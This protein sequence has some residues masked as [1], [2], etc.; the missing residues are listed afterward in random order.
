MRSDNLKKH[1]KICKKNEDVSPVHST[2]NENTIGDILNKVH[3][4]AQDRTANFSTL[5]QSK[6]EALEFKPK[7]D[8]PKP[9]AEIHSDSDSE[10]E[11]ESSET[12]SESD[13]EELKEKFRKLFNQLHHS[14]GVI[15]EL[16]LVLD[17]LEMHD[18]LT[19]EECNALKENIQ[20][21]IDEDDIHDR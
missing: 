6:T 21:R 19:A 8:L 14:I 20:K 15:N 13:L 12:G 2:N 5:P 9:I 10:V 7:L 17:E 4:R 16:A 3:K 1:E 11:D 18:F